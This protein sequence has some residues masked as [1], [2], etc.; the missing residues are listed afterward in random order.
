M[1]F[2]YTKPRLIEN[3]RASDLDP[4]HDIRQGDN[5]FAIFCVAD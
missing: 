3:L 2:S 1:L 5:H 4:A